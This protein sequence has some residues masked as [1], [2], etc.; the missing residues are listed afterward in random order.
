M[1]A[2]FFLQRTVLKLVIKRENKETYSPA[3]SPNV[4]PTLY[5]NGS[6]LFLS[7]KAVLDII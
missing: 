1:W 2:I 6:Y 3:L 5:S 7:P 4:D